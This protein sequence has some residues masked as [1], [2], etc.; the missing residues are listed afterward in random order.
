MKLKRNIMAM[1]RR[2]T[3]ERYNKEKRSKHF[4]DWGASS[5]TV[6]DLERAD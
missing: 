4:P 5:K 3:E 1:A 2:A 6:Q